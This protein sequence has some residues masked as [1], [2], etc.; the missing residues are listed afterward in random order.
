MLATDSRQN[1]TSDDNSGPLVQGAVTTS[2]PAYTDG[3]TNPLSLNA[4]GQLRVTDDANLPLLLAQVLGAHKELLQAIL[5]ELRTQTEFLK[6][7][8]NVSD[9]A[10]AVRS[11]NATLIN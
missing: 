7:G 3:K 10:D 6:Q 2:S 8:L 5:I 4:A 1:S 9:D 11:D